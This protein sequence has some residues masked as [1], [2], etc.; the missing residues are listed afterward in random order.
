MIV[1]YWAVDENIGLALT[2]IKDGYWAVD[3]N[4]DLVKPSAGATNFMR[5]IR[6]RN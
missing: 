5:I 1:A 2:P 6:S 3:E 4:I